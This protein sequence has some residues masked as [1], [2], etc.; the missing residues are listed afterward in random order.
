ME[1]IACM[2]CWGSWLKNSFL[3]LLGLKQSS[4]GSFHLGAKTFTFPLPRTWLSSILLYSSILSINWCISCM[5]FI[6][7]DFLR[8]KFIGSPTLKVRTGTSSKSPLI[9]LKNSQYLSEYV[10]KDSPFLIAIESKESKGLGILLHVTNLT[11]NTL[12]NS[13]YDLIDPSSNPSNYLMAMSSRVDGKTLY[14]RALFLE[15][16]VIL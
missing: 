2:S 16:M 5:S 1:F 13:S 12:V 7:R 14:I 4:R 6:M 8:S 9:S 15:W 3:S 10:F 11:P